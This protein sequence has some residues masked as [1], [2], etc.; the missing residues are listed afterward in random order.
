M[1][2]KFVARAVAFDSPGTLLPS[3]ILGLAVRI[4]IQEAR[5]VPSR[6][7]DVV[8]SVVLASSDEVGHV[9]LARVVVHRWRVAAGVGTVPTKRRG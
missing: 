6:D 4:P 1:Y 7:L 9:L 3:E 8:A 5:T 2:V